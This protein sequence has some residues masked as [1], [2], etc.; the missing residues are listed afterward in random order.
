M[1]YVKPDYCIDRDYE[2][3]K[4]ELFRNYECLLRLE[5]ILILKTINDRKK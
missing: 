5:H 3:L 1:K 4:C 2:C